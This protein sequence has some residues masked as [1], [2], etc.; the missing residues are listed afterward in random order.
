M[1][2]VYIEDLAGISQCRLVATTNENMRRYVGKSGIRG[3]YLMSD[4]SCICF[5]AMENGQ[6]FRTSLGDIEQPDDQMVTRLFTDN[7]GYEWEDFKDVEPVG[8]IRE[9][10]IGMTRRSSWVMAKMFS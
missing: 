1:G 7:S 3:D 5:F 2:N 10:M 9:W 4:G 6:F 8:A